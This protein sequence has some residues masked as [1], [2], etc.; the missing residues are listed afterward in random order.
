[1]E[2]GK[3]KSQR[4]QALPSP[5]QPGLP[6][7]RRA[8]PDQKLFFFLV[9]IRLLR[10][11]RSPDLSSRL[12]AL[13]ADLLLRRA[14]VRGDPSNPKQCVIVAIVNLDSVS[15]F[16]LASA[17]AELHSVIADIESVNEMTILTPN[18]TDAYWYDR[19]GSLRPPFACANLRHVPRS[20]HRTAKWYA[21]SL[22]TACGIR[23]CRGGGTTQ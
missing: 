16:H 6:S 3:G 18:D 20:L 9:L 5:F 1:M 21:V 14:L 23:R 2:T 11:R 15:D 17:T 8:A 10:E 22:I 13:S 12:Q 7:T 19:F 4:F